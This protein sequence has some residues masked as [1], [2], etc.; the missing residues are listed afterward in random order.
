MPLSGPDVIFRIGAFGPNPLIPA[1]MM[2][3]SPIA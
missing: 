3:P 2:T 1:P